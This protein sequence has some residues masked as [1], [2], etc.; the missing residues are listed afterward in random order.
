M[1]HQ[2]FLAQARRGSG[3]I[4]TEV[5]RVWLLG[6]FG[7]SVGSR[8]VE[9]NGWRLRKVVSLVKLLALAQG[10]KLHREQITAVLW[11]DLSAK[12]QANNLHRVL[13]FARGALE[14]TPASS[15]NSRYLVLQGDLLALC[16]NAGGAGSR[17]RCTA[18]SSTPW[19]TKPTHATGS[20]WTRSWV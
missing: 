19:S 11:P 1:A 2:R 14:A 3:G 12:S 15:T 13:H 10:Y 5:V 18:P 16:P 8:I 17:R 7:V 20:F 9:E 4:E 6:G